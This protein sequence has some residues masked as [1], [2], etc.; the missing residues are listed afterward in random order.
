MITTC[1]R[2]TYLAVLTV[3]EIQSLGKGDV[4]VFDDIQVLTDSSL[5]FAAVTHK[6]TL[7]KGNSLDKTTELSLN[8]DRNTVPTVRC[9]GK[10]K[11]RKNKK[12]RTPRKESGAAVSPAATTDRHQN[13]GETPNA[14]L[15]HQEIGVLEG[16]IRFLNVPGSSDSFDA[17][18]RGPPP[19]HPGQHQSRV[20]PLENDFD[21]ALDFHNAEQS[22]ATNP[23][24]P[25]GLH[26]DT[27]SATVLV[28]TLQHSLRSPHRVKAQEQFVCQRSPRHHP[29]HDRLQ[30]TTQWAKTTVR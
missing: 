19:Q 14:S 12:K 29:T 8:H 30:Q 22:P 13:E 3:Q 20:L 18:A 7:L 11:K 23:H 15:L 9:D 6:E 27:H 16:T 1:Q 24:A 17:F 4:H 25:D 28:P 26:H 2:H 10:E 21:E 5:Q